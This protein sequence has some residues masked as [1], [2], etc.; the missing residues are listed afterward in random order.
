[1]ANMDVL[2]VPCVAMLRSVFLSPLRAARAFT[3]VRSTAAFSQGLRSLH[4]LSSPS[5]PS[6]LALSFLFSC[7][8]CNQA[9]SLW[10]G[11]TP[12]P[13]QK[14]TNRL[15]Y[16]RCEGQRQKESSGVWEIVI[17]TVPC[18]LREH[19]HNVLNIGIAAV[20]LGKHYCRKFWHH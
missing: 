11:P 16:E 8:D 6:L 1:M 3:P 7:Q 14:A 12:L 13:A 18:M 17:K 15:N 4:P 2:A 10:P 9:F 19:K 5:L 20:C